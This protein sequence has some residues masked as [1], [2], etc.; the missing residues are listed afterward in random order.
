MPAGA[1][2]AARLR[3]TITRRRIRRAERAEVR[4]ITEDAFGF[5]RAQ[6]TT[7]LRGTLAKAEALARITTDPAELRTLERTRAWIASELRTRGETFDPR[8]CTFCR[9]PLNV[10][11]HCLNAECIRILSHPAR[12]TS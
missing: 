10:F 7:I 12:A 4:A 5:L 9:E 11:G 1:H 8:E 6:H 3:G 2:T